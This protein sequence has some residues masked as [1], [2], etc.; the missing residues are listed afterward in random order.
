M[1]EKTS[2]HSDLGLR[3]FARNA[4]TQSQR[5]RSRIRRAKCTL[6]RWTSTP[7][8]SEQRGGLLGSLLSS[9][10]C[11]VD[12]AFFSC[13]TLS[14]ENGVTESN[15][16][17]A[18]IRYTA[19]ERSREHYLVADHTK[20]DRTSFVHICSYDRLTALI[21]DTPLSEAW[22]EALESQGC[23]VIDQPPSQRPASLRETVA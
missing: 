23:Q 7:H 2:K 8:A 18:Q 20:F 21:T 11:H 12:K 14:I 13:R 10:G 15:D 5:E 1:P 17:W 4:Q 19:I 22:H 9:L 3:G 6:G 16:R